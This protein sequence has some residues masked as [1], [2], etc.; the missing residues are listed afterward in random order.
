MMAFV[1]ATLD[2]TGRYSYERGTDPNKE[3]ARVFQLIVLEKDY[4]F[5]WKIIVIVLS[6]LSAILLCIVG[7]CTHRVVGVKKESGEVSMRALLTERR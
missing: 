2:D 7:Y 1:Q 5:H 6:A 3:Y 4:C